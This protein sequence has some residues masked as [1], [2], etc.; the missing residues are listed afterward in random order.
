MALRQGLQSRE[1]QRVAEVTMINI[2]VE[3]MNRHVNVGHSQKRI[4]HI[5]VVT[6]SKQL[7]KNANKE[8]CDDTKDLPSINRLNICLKTKNTNQKYSMTLAKTS[9]HLGSNSTTEE[10]VKSE[11]IV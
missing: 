7:S 2:P 11:V 6:F 8:S 10:N 3:G 1:K 4:L 9:L 5:R